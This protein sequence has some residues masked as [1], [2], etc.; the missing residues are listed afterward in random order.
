MSFHQNAQLRMFD[1]TTI[2]VSQIIYK[3]TLYA[4]IRHSYMY[5]PVRSGTI[6]QK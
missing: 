2:Q 4:Y 5:E 3:Q 6:N 1:W